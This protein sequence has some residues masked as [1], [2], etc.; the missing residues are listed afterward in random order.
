MLSKALS[1]LPLEWRSIILLF[2]FMQQTDR[3]I[4][5]KLGLT[6]NTAYYRRKSTIRKMKKMLESYRNET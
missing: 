2:Y 3:Q 6:V 1:K 4:G 5:R